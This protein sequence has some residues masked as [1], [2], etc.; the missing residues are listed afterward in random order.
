MII[1]NLLLNFRAV[2]VN[3]PR[4]KKT[5]LLHANIK[6]AQTSQRI[7]AVWSAPLFFAVWKA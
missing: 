3:E 2:D 7:H 4:R 6:K 1:E 5:W